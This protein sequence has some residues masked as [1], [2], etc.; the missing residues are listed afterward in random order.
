[1]GLGN[2]WFTRF[3]TL[4]GYFQAPL[5]LED[6]DLK[7]SIT[8]WGRLRFFSAHMGVVS[9]GEE[10]NRRGDV[11]LAALPDSCKIV[12]NVFI[13]TASY[14]EHLQRVCQ[15]LQRRDNAGATLNPQK[16]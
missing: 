7:T 1:M 14:D 10:F 4:Q 16:F 2:R 15:V 12:D 3:D 9:S 13:C 8:P 6:R 11:A 5:R